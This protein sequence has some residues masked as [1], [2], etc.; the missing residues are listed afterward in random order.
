MQIK[1]LKGIG[2]KTS[3]L[4]AKLSVFSVEDLIAFYPRDYDIYEPPVFVNEINEY[5]DKPAVAIDAMVT[6]T[7]DFRR[8]G[9]LSI[10]STI[11][12]DEQ[13]QK[14]KATWFNMPYLK[15]AL[16]LG[17]RFVFRGRVIFKNGGYV[18]EQPAMYTMAEYSSLLNEMQPIYSITKGLSNKIVTKAVAQALEMTKIEQDYLPQYLKLKYQLSDY[19]FAIKSI[20]FPKN[21]EDFCEARKRLVFEEFFFFIMSVRQLKEHNDL[22]PN[23][24]VIPHDS[25]TDELI[26]TLPYSLTNAQVKACEEVKEN[27]AGNRLMNRLIQ[28]DV[29]SGKTIIA[30]LALMDVAYAGWQGAMMVPTEV[31]AKQQFESIN[32]MFEQYHINIRT[33]LLIGS[34]TAKEKRLE[35][36][37]IE[38][39]EAQIVIGTHA[40]IQE[41]VQYHNLALVITDEQHRFGVNQ[42][43]ALSNKGRQPHILVMSA[44]PIPR[45]LAIIIYGDLDI[46]VIDE[47][48]SNRLAIKNCVVNENYRPKAYEFIAEQVAQGRQTYVICPMV[49]ESENMEAEN[50]IDYSKQLKESLPKSISVE[51]LHGKMK[52]SEKN[53]IMKRFSS[54]KTDVLVSTTV[55]EV[56]VNVP[57]S[58][59]M[60]IENA[61]RFGLAQLHQLR[62]RVGRG[63]H[64][65]YCIFVSNSKS[66]KTK[67]RLEILNKSNDGFKIAEEDMKL[68]GPGDFF[69]RRQSGLMEFVIGDIFTDAGI[70]KDASDAANELLDLDPELRLEEN[71]IFKEKLVEF[72]EKCLNRLNI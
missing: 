56:G 46:S 27:L 37:K 55:I 24:Y 52:S 57:N 53:D 21:M 32:K 16:R 60:M 33:S 30:T 25:R 68:R 45:T 51:Y 65:S 3:E 48:P 26:K 20:H 50:V 8:A 40:L 70:L 35:Y 39:G 63:S 29:G 9:N 36:E 13:G 71:Q 19:S 4:F 64:Q 67:E 5:S 6:Q 31:L 43:E 44:T 10:V 15:N 47:M 54:G 69:G 41:K 34:M 14:I 38:S 23:H 7:P 49:E 22:Q 28:G 1:E 72:T 59:V 18:M 11:I 62:G 17:S 61:D 42:R 12:K 66:K 2:E 58:T